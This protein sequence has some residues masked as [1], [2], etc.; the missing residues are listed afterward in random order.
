MNKFVFGLH[1]AVHP[2]YEMPASNC[3]SCQYKI[4]AIT[5]GD[6]KPQPGE[7]T[8]C[9]NC[10]AIL[11]LD[12]LLHVQILT[13]WEG[14]TDPLRAALEAVSAKRRKEGRRKGKEVN[15]A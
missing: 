8:L 13:T 10:G 15:E 14:I 1:Q 7:P 9:W 11:R 5:G 4:S 12:E 6:T 2:T 3:P